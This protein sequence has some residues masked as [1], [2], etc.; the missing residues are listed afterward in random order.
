VI[1]RREKMRPVLIGHHHVAERGFA[2]DGTRDD[3]VASAID[4]HAMPVI[5]TLSARRTDPSESAILIIGHHEDVIVSASADDMAVELG[6]RA[7]EMPGHIRVTL[8][9]RRHR[10]GAVNQRAAR[11]FRPKILSAR[12]ELR[13]EDIIET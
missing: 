7:L 5:I 12:V 6:R 3:D 8:R 10:V 9:V 11:E 2:D 4:G 13:D 1:F